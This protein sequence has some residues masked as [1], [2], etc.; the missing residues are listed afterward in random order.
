MT[1]QLARRMRNLQEARELDDIDEAAYERGLAKLR[2][3]YGDAAVDALL[4]QPES[5]FTAPP[6]PITNTA[7]NQGAQGIFYG[8]V[9]IHGQRG[10]SATDLIGA[11]APII[12]GGAPTRVGADTSDQTSALSRAISGAA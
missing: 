5:A 10:K 4:H 8:T 6:Q 7:P 12:A 3:Q 11:Y 1:D 2:A 9:Y